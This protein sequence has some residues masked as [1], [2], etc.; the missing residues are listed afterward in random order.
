MNKYL[1]QINEL[2][3]N[4]KVRIYTLVSLIVILLF[5]IYA[6]STSS[7]GKSSRYYHIARP[8]SWVD[9]DVYGKERNLQGFIDDLLF[10][11][12]KKADFGLELISVVPDSLLKGLDTEEYDGIIS[13]MML[14]DSN[15][16]SYLFSD[17]FLLLGPVLVVSKSS[18]VTSLEQMEGKMVGIRSGSS[19]IFNLERDPK[20]V[21]ITYD[22]I[23][24][25]LEHLIANK[26]DG[27]VMDVWLA[28]VLTEGFYSDRLKI[29]TNP[30]NNSGLRLVT[31]NSAKWKP[32]IEE[33][34]KTLKEI[35]SDG[36]FRQ[37]IEKWSL[38][39]TE[40]LSKL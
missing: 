11:I 16:N 3:A 18:H 10:T 27:V 30:L 20:I 35:K 29:A 13:R 33:F 26:I 4:K 24:V 8:S 5:L 15:I 32:L 9:L 39:E 7:Q 6:L 25:A 2:W 23:N 12:A 36:T 19:A 22:N 21:I 31:L 37:L 34:N 28:K 1:K 38:I 40:P 14:N 17:P